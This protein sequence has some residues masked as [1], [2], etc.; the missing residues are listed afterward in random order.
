MPWRSARADFRPGVT[1]RTGRGRE[2]IDTQRCQLRSLP[3]GQLPFTPTRHLPG[4]PPGPPRPAAPDPTPAGHALRVV[5]HGGQRSG[6]R[7]D[8]VAGAEAS[9]GPGP[10]TWGWGGLRNLTNWLCPP[11]PRVLGPERKPFPARHVFWSTRDEVPGQMGGCSE[12]RTSPRRE[13]SHSWGPMSSQE[14]DSRPQ[15]GPGGGMAAP[16]SWGWNLRV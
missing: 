3:P 5:C 13:P 6:Q 2:V 8:D 4:P 16:S 11:P 15:R 12:G 14:R 7:W 1:G 9:E 10:G